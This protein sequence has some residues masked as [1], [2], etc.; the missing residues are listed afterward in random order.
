MINLESKAFKEGGMI[1]KRHG[2]NNGNIS[3]QVSWSGLPDGTKS[4]AIICD[5]P[6]APMGTWVHWVI[7]NI[8][9]TTT[10]LAEGI[11]PQEMLGD[12]TQQGT[13]DF[14]KIGYGGPCP[15]QGVHRYIF[16]IYALD[17]I[18]EVSSGITKDALLNAMEGHVLANGQLIGRYKK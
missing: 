13:N 10:N 12:G 1:P 8:P 18:L 4:V 7:Y 17:V 15:P 3:P 11:P 5:D 14:R 16:N 6:D 2:Y 9:P